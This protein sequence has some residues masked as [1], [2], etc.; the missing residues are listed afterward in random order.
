MNLITPREDFR[1]LKTRCLRIQYDSCLQ[2]ACKAC[3]KGFTSLCYGMVLPFRYL[4]TLEIIMTWLKLHKYYQSNRLLKIKNHD[5]HHWVR[6]QNLFVWKFM[7]YFITWSPPAIAWLVA[8]LLQA[9]VVAVALVVE[10][11]A[12]LHLGSEQIHLDSSKKKTKGR[13]ASYL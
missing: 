4:K 2:A 7:A 10:M 8:V 1:Y 9:L 13:V 5:F 3:L 11:M 6:K 12:A